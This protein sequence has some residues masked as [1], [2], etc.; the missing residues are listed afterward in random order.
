MLVDGGPQD[1]T[2]TEEGRPGFLSSSND[3]LGRKNKDKGVNQADK[4]R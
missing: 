3:T 1:T 2:E 4:K